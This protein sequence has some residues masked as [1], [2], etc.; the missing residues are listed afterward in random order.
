M[1]LCRNSIRAALP[2]DRLWDNIQS[3]PIPRPLKQY[4]LL[5][6][7]KRESKVAD[8]LDVTPVASDVAPVISDV[9]PV[10]SFAKPVRSDVN[11]FYKE[12]KDSIPSLKR[13]HEKSY[14]GLVKKYKLGDSL[15]W[16]AVP[17]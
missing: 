12:A 17:R 10:I 14:P 4:V 6:R 5:K 9:E 8:V 7:L 13:R 11:S 1:E 2:K 15:P 3:L 16:E